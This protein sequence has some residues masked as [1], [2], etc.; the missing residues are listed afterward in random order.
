MSQLLSRGSDIRQSVVNNNY[1]STHDGKQVSHSQLDSARSHIK[2]RYDI[3]SNLNVAQRKT[4]DGDIY[5]NNDRSTHEGKK[6][7][8]SQLDSARSQIKGRYDI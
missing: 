3:E 2:G 5:T 7:S 4:V 1:R 8:N 6:V